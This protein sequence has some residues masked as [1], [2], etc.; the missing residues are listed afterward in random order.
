M[1]H[2]EHNIRDDFPIFKNHPELVYLDSTATT[3]KPESVIKTMTSFVS[4]DYATIN[5]GIYT[6]SQKATEKCLAARKAVQSFI[7][8]KTENEI[9]FVK[10]TTE[11]INLIAKSYLKDTIK[12]SDSILLTDMEHHA[13]IVPWQQ[14]VKAE[15]IKVCGITETGELDIDDF[16]QKCNENTKLIS[17]THI[18]NVLGII[19]PIKELINYARQNSNAV[20]VID[21]AQAVGH[22][23]VDVQD[24]DCDFYCFS[25]HKL[26]GPTGIGVLYGKYELLEAMTPYQTGGDMIEYV[27]FEKTTFTKPPTKFEAGTPAIMEIMGLHECINYINSIGFKRI[28]S[29]E[30]ALYEQL[31]TEISGITELS[32]HGTSKQKAAILSFSLTDIHPHDIGTVMDQENVAIRVGHHC[33]QP[34]MRLLNV[35]ATARISIGCYNTAEDISRCVNALKKVIEFFK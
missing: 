34:L 22:M 33:A 35:P 10:G 8:A 9:V 16:K 21:G 13:N 26:Y 28:Q 31:C 14:V 6:I 23:S 12:D 15:Q 30:S 5:R 20:I 32:I 1:S 7:N 4:D 24:L 18:S 3:Q 19:N 17:I 25:A 29:I 27:S 2:Q 11:A